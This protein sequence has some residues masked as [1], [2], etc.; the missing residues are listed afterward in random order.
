MLFGKVKYRR[1]ASVVGRARDGIRLQQRRELKISAPNTL[2]SCFVCFPR[3][4]VCT[5][6]PSPRQRA[7]E[8]RTAVNRAAGGGY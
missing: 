2:S 1:F 8:R 4:F 3:H 7:M 6:D 5:R